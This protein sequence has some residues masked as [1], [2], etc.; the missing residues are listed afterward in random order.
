MCTTQG[1][2]AMSKVNFNMF[3][4]VRS[5]LMQ[6]SSI[7]AQYEKWEITRDLIS[8]KAVTKKGY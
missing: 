4:P 1:T 6:D 3:L 7:I 2:V 5:F 8:I